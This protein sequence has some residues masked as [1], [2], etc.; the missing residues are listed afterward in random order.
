MWRRQIFNI[1]HYYK[2]ALLDSAIS[3][4]FFLGR[5]SN[6][7]EMTSA[8]VLFALSD[9]FLMVALLFWWKESSSRRPWCSKACTHKGT[10]GIGQKQ[11]GC[12][13]LAVRLR[14]CGEEPSARHRTVCWAHH[15]FFVQKRKEGAASYF[16]ERA[17]SVCSCQLLLYKLCLHMEVV[18]SLCLI[19]K[20][21]L[22]GH[23]PIFLPL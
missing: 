18:L 6:V 11:Q 13:P 2:C 17:Q 22:L 23:F 3:E 20:N 19:G 21:I 16:Q 14:A 7:G 9:E 4:A 12:L 15:H 5:A 1:F 8:A 10:L